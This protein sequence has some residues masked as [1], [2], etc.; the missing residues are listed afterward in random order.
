MIFLHV[1]YELSCLYLPFYIIEFISIL[2]LE[3]V[4]S[5]Y[6]SRRTLAFRKLLINIAVL[7]VVSLILMLLVYAAYFQFYLHV[8]YHREP[9]FTDVAMLAAM[10]PAVYACLKGTYSSIRRLS[11]QPVSKDLSSSSTMSCTSS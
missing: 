4:S 1:L 6:T 9:N 5:I 3:L 10:Y 7:Q 8:V 2:A 11:Q